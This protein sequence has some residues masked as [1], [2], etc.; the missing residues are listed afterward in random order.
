MKTSMTMKNLKYLFIATIFIFLSC[1]KED[2][3]EQNASM[4][5]LHEYLTPEV[6]DAMVEMGFNINTGEDPPNIEGKYLASPLLLLQSSLENDSPP[7]TEFPDLEYIFTEQDNEDLSVFVE[8]YEAATGTTGEGSGALII[9][10]GT[11]FSVFVKQELEDGNGH[12]YIGVEAISGD[13]FDTGIIDFQ[14][15][16][17]ML[18]D[19][20]NPNGNLIPNNTG[21]LFEDGDTK[22]DMVV[23]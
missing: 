1:S 11:F 7:G 18:D 14:M 4:A 10:E 13:L 17:M 8:S 12:T 19:R 21:R 6:V 15:A 3:E 23:N 20:G 16:N 22:A 9:G 5:A 2:R